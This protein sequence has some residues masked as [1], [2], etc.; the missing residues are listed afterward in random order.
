M[1]IVGG[2]GVADMRF[3]VHIVIRC[4]GGVG[5]LDVDGAC[6]AEIDMQLVQIVIIG[7]NWWL[8]VNLIKALISWIVH[9]NL[10]VICTDNKWQDK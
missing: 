6:G 9:Y 1:A 8:D 4:A 5:V 2:G 3:T 7:H 10:F